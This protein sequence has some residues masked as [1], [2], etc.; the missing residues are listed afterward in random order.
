ML[1]ST[2]T[3]IGGGLAGSEAAWQLAERGIPVRL[4]EMRPHRMTPAHRT[5]RLGELVCSNSLK[6]DE[7]GTA[8]YLLKEELRRAG[9][10]LIRL[11]ATCRVPA[12][13]ALAV[14][15]E[16][17]AERITQ[18]ITT[19]PLITLIREE[20]ARIPSDG[21][22]II[23]TGPLTSEAL[24][25]EIRRLTGRGHLYFYDA[26]SPIV[27]AETI[28][29]DVVFRASRYGKGGDDYLN[30][31]LTKE[32]YDRFYDALMQAEKVALHDFDR[33]CYFEGCLPIEEL[34]RRGRETLLYG[35]MK[36]VGL[37]DP[38][39]GRPP[40][41]VVQ[42]RQENLLADSYNLV[43]FQ[44][45]LKWGEQKR[46]FRLIPGLERAEFI[47]YGM[48]HRN[49]YINSPACLTE[50]LQLR[51]D[52]RLF[53]AGQICGVE[54]YVECIA[55]G[56]MVALFVSDLLAGR[57]PVPPPRTTA[58]GSLLHYVAHSDPENF[59]PGNITFALLPPL[60]EEGGRKLPKAE[61]HRRQIERALCDFEQW[62][63]PRR[64]R[65]DLPSLLSAESR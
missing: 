9:S 34:A 2:V 5:D 11:A 45:Q 28:N 13:A 47:R 54:G 27:D 25:E 37:V 55:T 4:Y 24:S 43:G 32:E 51:A 39:T 65:V 3:I 33:A 41:A 48:V 59:Q 63:A 12:G 26:I 50:T 16:L 61:R 42:L 18:A 30:C 44:T 31:P 7:P 40:Y 62:I 6:S 36:P 10:L 52:P 20:V 64:V 56:L 14:D 23:A 53:F 29:Y 46:V 21:I 58:F 35:P 8:S 19:H 15:R 60:E 17:F 1:R 49:T 38:R 57:E 22:V